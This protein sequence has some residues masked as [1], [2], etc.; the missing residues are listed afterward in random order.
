MYSIEKKIFNGDA[1]CYF[2]LAVPIILAPG[3]HDR[4]IKIMYHYD[5]IPLL[6]LNEDFNHLMTTINFQVLNLLKP[7]LIILQHPD[8]FAK[9]KANPK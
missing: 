3:R 6:S 4:K 9:S 8:H 5:N 2:R 1:F 7:D